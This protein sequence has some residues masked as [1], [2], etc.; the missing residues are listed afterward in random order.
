[1]K[2]L[3][4]FL[5]TVT[6]CQRKTLVGAA[7]FIIEIIERTFWRWRWN[8]GSFRCPFDRQRI[9]VGKI[10]G[11]FLKRRLDLMNECVINVRL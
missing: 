5:W 2:Y 3:L 4:I 6:H 11:L 8:I 7:H 9:I 1:M 10:N